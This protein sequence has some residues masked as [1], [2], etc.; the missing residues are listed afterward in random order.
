MKLLNAIL[1]ILFPSYCISCDKV[2]LDLCIDCLSKCGES[3]RDSAKW[4]FPVY[5]YR[6]PVIKKSIWLLKYKNKRGLAKVF[7]E[8]MYG[9]IIEE[10]AELSL[11]ENFRNPLLIPI[12]LSKIRHKERG[13]NQVELICQELLKLDEGQNFQLEKDVLIRVKDGVHQARI[14]NRKDRLKNIVGAFNI[15]NEDK[16]KGRN[17]ILID[18]V[19]TTGGTLTEA[20]KVLKDRGAKKVIA[21]TVAH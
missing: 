10:L 9:T 1:N 12:P 5:D 18:D 14:E 16:I 8:A 11:M 21:F 7:A 2:G 15:K 19:T 4:M 17:I 3:E 6:Q 13:F 20:R